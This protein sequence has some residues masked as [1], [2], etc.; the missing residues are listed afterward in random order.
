MTATN[1]RVQ[2]YGLAGLAIT[3]QA[4]YYRV[5]TEAINEHFWLGSEGVL[6]FPAADNP[7]SRRGWA[8]YF[9]DETDA[10]DAA[11]LVRFGRSSMITLDSYPA[12]LKTPL[13]VHELLVR[14]GAGGGTAVAA[15]V[16]TLPLTRMEAAANIRLGHLPDVEPD[17]FPFLITSAEWQAPHPLSRWAAQPEGKRRPR[18]PSLRIEVPPDRKKPDRFYQRVADLYLWLSSQSSRPAEDLA[19]ANGVPASTVHRWIKEARRRDI[20]TFGRG[21]DPR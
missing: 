10:V 21:K 3:L 12:Q 4:L 18:R 17:D 14:T 15:A 8:A 1:S 2:T 11:I 9:S 5:V 16:R 19:E 13:V 7:W 20:L 6:C